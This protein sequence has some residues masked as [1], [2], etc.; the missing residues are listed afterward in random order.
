MPK[1]FDT[2]LTDALDLA[3]HAAQTAG[4]A[5]AR[6][7]GRKRT[8]HQRIAL[9]T[10]SLVLVAVG[11]TAAFKVASG[12]NGA[13]PGLIGS[14]PSASA[15][16]SPTPGLA[17]AP[18]NPSASPSV[19]PSASATADTSASSAAS[20]A[21][22]SPDPHKVV[23]SAWLSPSQLPFDSALRWTAVATGTG[24]MPGANAL[25]NTVYLNT[26][27]AAYQTLTMCGDP[28]QLLS[29]TIGEQ[30]T[31]YDS[32]PI[33]ATNNNQAWQH[34][35]FFTDAKAAAQAYAWLQ[36]QYTAVCANGAQLT[37]EA[38]AANQSAWLMVVGT[39]HNADR[40]DYEREY[41]VLAGSTITYVSVLSYTQVLP[42]KFDDNAELILI[43]NHACVYGGLCK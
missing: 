9:S 26:N 39:G 11:A 25:T 13:A 36:S 43:A 3:G 7:R 4:P 37:R 33:T 23:A 29:R 32:N 14:S 8:L 27:D 19:P 41:F 6:I 5:A 35:F 18:A 21:S 30:Y 28:S 16:A 10:A 34:I 38:G 2:T 12:H 31:N 22:S 20:G 15:T 24:G 17:T 40:P 1:D 42:T